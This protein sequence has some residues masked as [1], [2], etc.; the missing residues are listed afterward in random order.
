MRGRIYGRVAEL[1]RA[2]EVTADG[3]ATIKM[4]E[5]R[6]MV[7][8]WG[9]FMGRPGAYDLVT[10]SGIRP[11]LAEWLDRRFGSVNYYVTQLLTGHGSFGHFLRKIGKRASPACLL[12][13]G[14]DDDLAHTL[15][16]CRAFA[17]ERSAVFADLGCDPDGPVCLADVVGGMLRSRDDWLAFGRFAAV[18]MSRK[19]EAEGS[20]V[21]LVPPGSPVT[22]DT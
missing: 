14:R 22:S 6:V 2:G 15:F 7:R 8:Q 5:R 9:L 21:G 16:A 20:Q 10:I 17:S 18:I 13:D 19:I 3:I 12:C 1:R 4:E 11:R